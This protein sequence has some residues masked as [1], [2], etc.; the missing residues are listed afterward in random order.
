MPELLRRARLVLLAT[1]S[2]KSSQCEQE[3]FRISARIV[4]SAPL[5]SLVV[6]NNSPI[7]RSSLSLDDDA[8]L[9]SKTDKMRITVLPTGAP[10]V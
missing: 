4:E 3:G 8:L 10:M 2:Q 9:G 6:E 1:C 5:E 7:A